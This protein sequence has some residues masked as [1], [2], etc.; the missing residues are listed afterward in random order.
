MTAPLSPG[1]PS[2]ADLGER[3]AALLAARAALAGVEAALP[4]QPGRVLAEL[5]ELADEVAALAGAMRVV[6]AAEAVRVGQP[7]AESLDPHGWVTAHAPGLRQGGARQVSALAVAAAGAAVGSGLGVQL[8]A[9]TESEGTDT[10]GSRIDA[11]TPLGVLWPRVAT[12]EAGPAV[13]AAV[14]REI[15]RLVPRLI[16]AAVPTVTGAMIDVAVAAGPGQPARVREALLAK[17]GLDGELDRDH[18]KLAAAAYLSSPQITGGISEYRMGL[19]PEQAAVVEAAVGALSA[20]APDPVTGQPDLRPAGQRRAEALVELVRGAVAADCADAGRDGAAGATT[21]LYVTM[22]L[23][24]LLT[25]LAST[26]AAGPDHA[27]TGSWPRSTRRDGCG[28]V[29]GSI[30]D[31]V[32]LGPETV[33]RL[34][35]DA[36]LIPVVLGGSG[37]ILDL[38]RTVRLYTRAQRRAL[39]LRDRGCTYPGCHAP[40]AWARAHH[41]RHWVDHGPSSLDNAALLCQR[42]HTLV[43]QR[44]LWAAVGLPDEQGRCVHWDLAYGSYDRHFRRAHPPEAA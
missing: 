40:A 27:T 15:T 32:I 21:A 16:P 19:T 42:H 29:L 39:V 28:Q 41:I 9:P 23:E 14:L 6:V 22:H 17:H 2:Q 5:L 4:G 35:C 31:Q 44:R 20:P 36:D 26:G 13:A 18:E 11:Q 12:G 24:D 43:H 33:R 3:R 8:G 34:A 25:G 30:A 38:G 37:E 1:K 10:V 7:G